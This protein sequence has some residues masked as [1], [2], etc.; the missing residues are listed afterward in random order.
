MP[1]P[2]PNKN[3]KKQSFIQRCMS[4]EK[5]TEEFSD[6]EQRYAVCQSQWEDKKKNAK[7]SLQLPNGDEI[8]I[9]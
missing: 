8:I 9:N 4:N 5:A 2:T 6:N 7:A 3:E 1:L